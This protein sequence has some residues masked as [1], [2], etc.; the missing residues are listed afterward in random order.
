MKEDTIIAMSTPAGNAGV[1]VIRISGTKAKEILQSLTRENIDFEPRKMYL[2]TVHFKDMN[3]KCLVVYFQ[4][5]MSYTGED[6]VEI[7][8]HGGFL[9]AQKIIDSFSNDFLETKYFKS[10][11]YEKV[12]EQRKEIEGLLHD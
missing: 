9:I 4:N 10:R 12:S 8:S 3:D 2:K 7:Q 11:I 1:A 5:P 6:V